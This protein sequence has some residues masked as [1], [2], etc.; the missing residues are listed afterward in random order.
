VRDYTHDL[1]QVLVE[2][3]WD[4]DYY[5]NHMLA[6]ADNSSLDIGLCSEWMY[7]PRKDL[8]TSIETLSLAIF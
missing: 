3:N 7:S 1:N 6:G 4:I 5:R 8:Y 2:N